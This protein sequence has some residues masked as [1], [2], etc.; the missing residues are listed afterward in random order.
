MKYT[1][2]D[3]SFWLFQNRFTGSVPTELGGL[4]KMSEAFILT[5]NNFVPSSVPTELGRLV[6][7]KDSFGFEGMQLTGP[8]ILSRSRF[9]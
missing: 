9:V 3:I 1:K 8:G 6:E 2:M 4:T 5:R 7:M